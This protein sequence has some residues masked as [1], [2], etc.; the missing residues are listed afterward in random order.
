MLPITFRYRI[1]RPS[2]ESA[3]L[4]IPE[5]ALS[6]TIDHELLLNNTVLYLLYSIV[7]ASTVGR[8]TESSM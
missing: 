8:T 1:W 6:L 5:L 2:L 4:K 3:R 7:I